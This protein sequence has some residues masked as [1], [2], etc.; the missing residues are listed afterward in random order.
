MDLKYT[1]SDFPDGFQFGTSTSSYQIEGSSFGGCGPS[2]W[3]TFAETPSNVAGGETG[4]RACEHY[5]RWEE[6]FDLLKSAGFDTYRFSTSW[7]RIIPEGTGSVNQQALDYYERLV[8]GL[9]ERDINPVVMLYHWDLPAALSDRGGWS[10]PDIANWFAD[11]TEVV[12]KRIGD[13]LHAAAT[14]N[15]PWC[16]AWLCHYL[17]IHAPGI[18]NIRTAVRAM[19]FVL[20]AHSKSLSAMRS[21]GLDNIGLALNFEYPQPAD[22]SENAHQAA[23]LYDGIYNRWFIEALS[24]GRYPE[25]VLSVFEPFMPKGYEDDLQAISAPID[26]LGINY[27]TRKLISPGPTGEPTDFIESTGDLEQTTMGWEVYPEGLNYFLSRLHQNYTGDLPLIVT[28]NGMSSNDVVVDGQ[29]EDPQRIEFI[30]RHLTEIKNVISNGVPVRGYLIWS[31]LD[32]FEWAL[33]YEKRF[34]LVHV[35]FDTQNRTPKDSF[36]ALASALSDP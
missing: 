14:I 15:E 4:A 12:M 19:H 13:R 17:G 33:G 6:D 3:D 22:D 31:L 27:Y 28:E 21:L 26:W 25:D 1:R 35:D 10:N 29:V 34:G 36:K 16:I 18:K 2:H 23:R 32:N 11:Y 9:L 30:N 7:S 20:L 24:K 5:L 8:D